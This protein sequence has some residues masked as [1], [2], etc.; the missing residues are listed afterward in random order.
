MSTI[1]KILTGKVLYAVYFLKINPNN[2]SLNFSPS[3]HVHVI[4]KK[5]ISNTLYIWAHISGGAVG[6]GFEQLECGGHEIYK[7]EVRIISASLENE[8]NA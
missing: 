2:G 1:S 5:K 6:V 8:K 7:F 3:H 4:S